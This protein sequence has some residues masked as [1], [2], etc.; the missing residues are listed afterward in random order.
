MRSDCSLLIDTCDKYRDAWNICSETIRIN[1][2]DCHYKKI[3][4]T[5]KADIPD[6]YIFDEVIHVDAT[7]WSIMLHKALEKIESK[8]I[9]FMLEDQWSI[10]PINQDRIDMAIDKME[11]DND[12]AVVYLETAKE[13]GV[14]KTIKVDNDYNELVWGSPYR[15]SCAPGI[16]R[17][18]FLYK[19]TEEAISPWDFERIKS[20][21]EI[22]KNVKVLE[23]QNSGWSRIDETGA[24]Y[25]GKWV[26]GVRKYAQSLGIEIDLNS[27]HEQSLLDVL[28]RRI[29]DFIF[30]LC[31]SLIIGVQK[32]I[33]N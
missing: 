33:K 2:S 28:K 8:Y 11:N 22:G 4:L 12:I 23:L 27:R 6:G 20:F 29:K 5:E 26:P 19:M 1:W 30:N 18:D 21:D 7:N 24:I 32:Y 25:R 9:I 15:L 16:F 10:T 31:P 14:K 3:M 17:K 13:G